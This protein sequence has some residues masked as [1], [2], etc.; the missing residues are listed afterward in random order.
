MVSQRPEDEPA[1]RAREEGEPEDGEAAEQLGRGVVGGEEGG[2][3]VGGEE[4][5]HRE[6]VE[7][8]RLSDGAADRRADATGAGRRSGLGLRALL[9]ILIGESSRVHVTRLWCWLPADTA[10]AC[11]IGRRFRTWP[12]RSAG[13]GVRRGTRTWTANGTSRSRS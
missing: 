10:A 9:L 4:A 1:Q 8:D 13:V 12:A 5:L 6:V 2:A 7:L 11:H 3:D